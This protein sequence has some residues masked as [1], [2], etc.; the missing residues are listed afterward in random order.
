MRRIDQEDY[1]ALD[2][3]GHPVRHE[4]TREGQEGIG[5]GSRARS[6]AKTHSEAAAEFRETGS[7][8]VRR[9][10]GKPAL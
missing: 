9:P 2:G 10:P 1:K 3:K 6:D 4:P 7:A 8:H 5:R